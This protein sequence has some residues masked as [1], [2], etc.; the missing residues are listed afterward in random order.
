MQ[1]VGRA[2][3]GNICSYNGNI[4]GIVLEQRPS[5]RLTFKST[6]KILSSGKTNDYQLQDCTVANDSEQ[7]SWL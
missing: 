2:L 7:V 6:V 3:A 4:L 5:F 1:H